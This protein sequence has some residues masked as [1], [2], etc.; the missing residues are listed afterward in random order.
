M[1]PMVH[2]ISGGTETLKL[3]RKR[4][5]DL[6]IPDIQMQEMN[7]IEVLKIII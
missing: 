6:A 1:N 3:I 7:D 5:P 2:A 4:N